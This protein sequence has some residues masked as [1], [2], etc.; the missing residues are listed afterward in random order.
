MAT[1]LTVT[2]DPASLTPLSTGF[3]VASSGTNTLITGTPGKSIRVL[4]MEGIATAAVTI[5][6][7]DS[8]GNVVWS[9]SAN[10]Q[11]LAANG[12]FVLPYCATGW[13]QCAIGSDLQ[14][15]LGGAQ[16]FSGGIV[17]LLV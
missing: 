7:K 16:A 4:A 6:L 14:I 3:G 15:V 13:F 5:Y 10:P 2:A 1:S 11:S 12:G 17:Y 9:T 8:Q